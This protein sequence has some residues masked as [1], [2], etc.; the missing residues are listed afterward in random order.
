V[1]AGRRGGGIQ[2]LNASVFGA[3]SP[4]DA[5]AEFERILARVVVPR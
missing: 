1:L 2:L 3:A 4:D 5:A